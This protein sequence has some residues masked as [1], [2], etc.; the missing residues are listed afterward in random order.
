MPTKSHNSTVYGTNQDSKHAEDTHSMFI[1]VFAFQFIKQAFPSAVAFV[2][3]RFAAAAVTCAADDA[4][5]ASVVGA[6]AA[7]AAAGAS[8]TDAFDASADSAAAAVAAAAANLVNTIKGVDILEYFQIKT[9][10]ET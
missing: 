7:A 5:V 2:A 3:A 4:T 9:K 10:C 6:A 8:D 1:I